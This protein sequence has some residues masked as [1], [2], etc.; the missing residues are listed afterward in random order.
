M[1]VISGS[2]IQAF[3]DDI[4]IL[5]QKMS[6][7]T[8]HTDGASR[9]NPGVS[10]AGALIEDSSGKVL[11]EICKYLGDNCTNNQAEYSS[12][13]LALEEA[14]KL[15][16]TSIKIY[17][18]SELMVRQIKGEYR[19]KNPGIKPLFEEAMKLLKKISTHTI[20]HIPREQNKRADKLANLAIDGQML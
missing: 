10:G 20:E 7:L 4:I 17:A 3:G 12:L 18:D 6:E 9:G 2:P 5:G 16:A 8:I 19:V 14:I 13:I 15:K 1:I 11:A